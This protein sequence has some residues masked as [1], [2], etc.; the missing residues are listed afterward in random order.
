MAALNRNIGGSQRVKYSSEGNIGRFRSLARVTIHVADAGQQAAYRSNRRNLPTRKLIFID[1]CFVMNGFGT[2]VPTILFEFLADL[3][4]LVDHFWTVFPG[5][6][7]RCSGLGMECC[8]RFVDCPLSKSI[9]NTPGDFLSLAEFA[10]AQSIWL[11]GVEVDD[12]GS[13]ARWKGTYHVPDSARKRSCFVHELLRHGVHEAMSSYVHK[14]PNR[15]S[16]Y[17]CSDDLVPLF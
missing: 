4:Q 17:F 16:G 6:L 10:D 3:H 11:C 5:W 12:H 2:V 13:Y 8:S 14:V 9:E 1:S 7:S 15:A